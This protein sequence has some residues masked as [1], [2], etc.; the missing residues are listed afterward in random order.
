MAKLKKFKKHRASVEFEYEFENGEVL[1]FTYLAT[2][3]NQLSKLVNINTKDTKGQ[4]EASIAILEENIVGDRV[5]DLINEIKEMNI[6]D[7]KAE[8][9]AEL[10][11]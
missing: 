4:L 10:G 11:K 2:T 9:D 8:L 3:T 7:F 1:S 5:D 6:Y